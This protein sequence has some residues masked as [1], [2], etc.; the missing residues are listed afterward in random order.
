[1]VMYMWIRS[2]NFASVSTILEVVCFGFS[3]HFNN[4]FNSVEHSPLKLL[5]YNALERLLSS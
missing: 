2:I 1:M 4:S 5:F 3:F